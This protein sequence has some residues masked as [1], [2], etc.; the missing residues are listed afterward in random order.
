MKHTHDDISIPVFILISVVCSVLIGVFVGL[1]S[2][3]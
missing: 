3:L 2:Y 1:L